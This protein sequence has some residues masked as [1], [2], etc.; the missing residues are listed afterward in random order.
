[1]PTALPPSTMTTDERLDEVAAI[2]A[3]GIR[4][5]RLKNQVVNLPDNQRLSSTTTGHQSAH[6]GGETRPQRK[7]R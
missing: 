1:M 5:L 6:G 3:A 7:T 2:L 4:R